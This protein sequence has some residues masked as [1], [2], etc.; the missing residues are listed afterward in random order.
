[1][2]FPPNDLAFSGA[3]CLLRKTNLR[4]SKAFKLRFLH[5]KLEKGGISN[6]E[7]RRTAEAGPI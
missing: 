7:L 5:F 6:E 2:A 4:L 3:R 1:M